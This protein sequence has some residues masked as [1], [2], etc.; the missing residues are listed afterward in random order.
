M[1]AAFVKGSAKVTV[2]DIEKPKPG[3]GEI[4]VQMHACGICGSDVEK[5]FG[6]YSQPSMKLGHEPSGIISEVGENVSG[7]KKGDRVFV[8]HHVPCYSCH[9]CLHGNETMCEKYYETN[10][11]PCGLSE[12]FVVPAWNVEHGG[13]LKIPDLISF[14]EAAMIEPLAC[15][16]RAWKKF[17]FQKGDSVAI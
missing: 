10:L 2:E 17:P 6:K 16:V 13:V 14:E 7:F 1:K 15:C 8:H 12:Q 3:K 11:S 4:M 9:Y 5:V